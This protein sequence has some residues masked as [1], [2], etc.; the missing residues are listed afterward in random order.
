[1]SRHATRTSFEEPSIDGDRSAV[2]LESACENVCDAESRSGLLRRRHAHLS[3]IGWR[4]HE[5]LP[6]DQGI[7]LDLLRK[8]VNEPGLNARSRANLERQD[9][10]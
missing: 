3:R 7:F 8:K 5:P 1:M 2:C 6:P 9:G 10:H 4:E